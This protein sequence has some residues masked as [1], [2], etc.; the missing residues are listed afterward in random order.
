MD[1][2]GY[3]LLAQRSWF[4]A[5]LKTLVSH[6]RRFVCDGIMQNID[7]SSLRFAFRNRVV[8]RMYDARHRAGA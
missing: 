4:I 8:I 3:P 5:T 1:P 7:C 6:G 2:S